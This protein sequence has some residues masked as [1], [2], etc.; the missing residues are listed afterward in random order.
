MPPNSPEV[1]PSISVSQLPTPPTSTNSSTN[2]SFWVRIQLWIIVK[3]TLPNKYDNK[4][5]KRYNKSN[6]YL[7]RFC[8][9]LYLLN[10]YN[11]KL[12]I[13]SSSLISRRLSFNFAINRNKRNNNNNNKNW[14]HIQTTQSLPYLSFLLTYLAETFRE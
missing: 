8:F 6:K 13:I 11:N 10:K 3:S 7:F 14:Q 5:C 2:T 1:Y 12:K 4:L 9:L